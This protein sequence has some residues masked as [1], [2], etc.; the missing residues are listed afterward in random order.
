[1]A[2]R[3]PMSAPSSGPPIFETAAPL[4]ALA[5]RGGMIEEMARKKHHCRP[6]ENLG[7]IPVWGCCLYLQKCA[8]STTNHVRVFPSPASCLAYEESRPMRRLIFAEVGLG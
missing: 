6:V 7:L 1:M 5:D 3:G 8:A 4:S 2:R